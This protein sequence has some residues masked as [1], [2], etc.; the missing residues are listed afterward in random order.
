MENRLLKETVVAEAAAMTFTSQ[1]T[2]IY[3]TMTA[4][5]KDKEGST[6]NTFPFA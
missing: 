1:P 4:A 3:S 5:T 2:C 6:G